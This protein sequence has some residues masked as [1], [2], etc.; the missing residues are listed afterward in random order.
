MQ[1]KQI[2]EYMLLNKI[3]QG[4]FSKVYM[5]QHL[6]SQTKYACKVIRR[7]SLGRR[8]MNHLYNEIKVL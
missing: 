5:C 8:G 7:N 3:G 6:V 2:G 1:V 4:V